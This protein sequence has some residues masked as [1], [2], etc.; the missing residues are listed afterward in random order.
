[1]TFAYEYQAVLDGGPWTDIRRHL[2]RLYEITYEYTWSRVLELGVRSGQSTLAFLAAAER[3]GG[4]VWSIDI[5]KPQVPAHWFTRSDI[6]TF[7]CGDDRVVNHDYPVDV[8][9]V[10][11]SHE[12]QHTL[13]ELDRFM[14][15]VV[16]GGAALFHDTQWGTWRDACAVPGAY[17]PVAC[18]LDTWCEQRGLTWVN[19][20]GSFGLGEIRV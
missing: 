11:T 10:D 12:Y 5:D 4:H 9:F 19:H 14:P 18:A 8:L 3:T 17:G 20:P 6:W 16:P 15:L 2:P 1:M 7:T 13:H